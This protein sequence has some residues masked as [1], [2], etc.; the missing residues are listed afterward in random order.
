M[1]KGEVSREF[2]VISKPKNVC[3]SIETKKIS[4]FV[5]RYHPN[6]I[7]LSINASD[8]SQSRLEWI[9]T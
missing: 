9:E 5:I 1:F 6:A 8:Q 7:K 3:L 2:S 4:S